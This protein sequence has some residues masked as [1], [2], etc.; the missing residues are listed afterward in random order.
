VLG[1]LLGRKAISTSTLGR[2]TTAARGMSRTMKESQDIELAKQNMAAAEQQKAELE[3]QIQA[4]MQQLS[5]ALD[6]ASEPLTPFVLKPKRTDIVV[7]IVALAWAPAWQDA[8]GTV[9]PAWKT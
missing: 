2:A 3:A 8:D 5:G 7:Q 9:S 4:D 1:A 6:P